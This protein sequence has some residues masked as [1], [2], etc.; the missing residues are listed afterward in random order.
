MRRFLI[1][2]L[3]A[4]ALPAHADGLA[5]LRA[6]LVRG[7][8]QGPCKAQLDTSTVRKL[9]EGKDAD[10]EQGSASVMVDDGTRGMNLAYSK[11]ILARIDAEQRARVKDPNSKTPTLL[12]LGELGPDDVVTMVSSAS[13]MQR[14]LDKARFRSERAETYQGKPARALSFD[15]PMSTLS[16]RD[17]K[18]TK[19]FEA[20]FDVWIAPDGTPLASRMRQTRSGRAFLV[21]SFDATFEDQRVYGLVGE[22]LVT[23]RRELTGKASGAGERDDSRVITTL[24]PQS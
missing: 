15:I 8:V 11:E 6:A 18:Y 14:T 20:V 24:Q 4:A 16:A 22:R 10:E 2:A 12:A 23:L 3:L 5:D 1:L 13:G 19:K 21:V 9:G 17:L 7:A